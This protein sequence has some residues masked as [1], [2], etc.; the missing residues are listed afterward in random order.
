MNFTF[1]KATN[2]ANF[3]AAFDCSQLFQNAERFGD[4]S[5]CVF[6]SDT[7]VLRISLGSQANIILGNHVIT[8]LDVFENAHQLLD[9]SGI[10]EQAV[11]ISVEGKPSYFP[12][13]F[14]ASLKNHKK[15]EFH[16]LQA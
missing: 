11:G 13:S 1:S 14:F 7:S 15:H 9:E 6:M 12:I 16:F 5:S 4:G 10:S 3:D 8:T 2:K